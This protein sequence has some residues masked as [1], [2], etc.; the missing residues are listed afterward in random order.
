MAGCRVMIVNEDPGFREMLT[1]LVTEYGFAA[2]PA[3]D[4][5]DAL[6][7]IY[8]IEPQIIVADSELSCLSG[9]DFLPFVRRR[10]PEIGVVV[11]RDAELQITMPP[12]DRIVSRRNWDSYRLV[13]A[14]AELASEY[15]LRAPVPSEP[16]DSGAAEITSNSFATCPWCAQLQKAASIAKL[17]YFLVKLWAR[18]HPD[19][20]DPEKHDPHAQEQLKKALTDLQLHQRKAHSAATLS[21]PIPVP[22]FEVRTGS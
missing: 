4:G 13:A 21:Q 20:P 17:N 11:L 7:Q 18:M 14:L 5:I 10:F 9:F 12:A 6:R 22:A 19:D 2:Y 16:A 8:D 1:A 3:A 15:P